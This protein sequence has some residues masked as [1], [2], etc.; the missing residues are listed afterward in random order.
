[1]IFASDLDRTLIYSEKFL[2]SFLGQVKA[3]ET[4]QYHSYMTE[5][6]AEL[7]KYIAGKLLFVPCTTRTIEQ[8][9]RIDFFQT[10][11]KPDYAITSNGANLIIGGVVDK[12]YKETMNRLLMH[13]CAAGYDILKEFNRLGSDVWAQPLRNA[14]EVFYYCIIEREKIPLKELDSFCNW[15]RGQNWEVSLQG[16]KLY[17]VPK[18][19][20]KWTALKRI[21]EMT[22]DHRVV[23]A[24]DS[25]LDL[26]L[27]QGADYAFIPAHG[28]LYE[29]LE[30]LLDNW[31]FTE[32]SGLLAGE[33]ILQ[34]VIKVVKSQK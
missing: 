2:E 20:N 12:G 19:I 7:L 1:M 27:L 5:T 34:A 16:R 25:L 23:A 30:C 4:G 21:T 13:H 9:L 6:A 31:L 28:E 33:E 22:G 26:P 3:A 10:A 15:A 11:L 29:Q 17:L 18:V 8:Y 32:S 14:D 24:G